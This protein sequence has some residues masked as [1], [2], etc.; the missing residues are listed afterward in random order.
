MDSVMRDM[1]GREAIC[2]QHQIG[3]FDNLSPRL[4]ALN[5]PTC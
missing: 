1:V 3:A 5:L 4:S 2:M